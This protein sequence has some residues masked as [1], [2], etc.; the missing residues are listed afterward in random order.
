MFIVITNR[1]YTMKLKMLAA[2]VVATTI[3]AGAKPV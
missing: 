2:V 1:R 3:S